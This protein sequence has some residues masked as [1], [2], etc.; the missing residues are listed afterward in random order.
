MNALTDRLKPKEGRVKRLFDGRTGQAITSLQ[1][2]HD[3]QNLVASA[4]TKRLIK[5]IY[6]FVDFNTISEVRR[7]SQ[8][9]AEPSRIITIYPNGDMVS[10]GI[11]LSISK[12]RFP[13]MKRL[14]EHIMKELPQYTGRLTTIYTTTGER[15]Q[16]IEEIAH[17]GSYVAVASPDAFQRVKYN[18]DGYKRQEMASQP[19]PAV[20]HS[21][22]SRAAQILEKSKKIL[23]PVP[24]EPQSRAPLSKDPAHAAPEPAAAASPPTIP[25]KKTGAPHPDTTGGAKKP[26][27]GAQANS[28]PNSHPTSKNNSKTN[29]KSNLGAELTEPLPQSP[30]GDIQTF[31]SNPSEPKVL[32]VKRVGEK[33]PATLT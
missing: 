8:L 30:P 27:I 25:V 33:D 12:F 11:N 15:I 1:D 21:T 4:N 23:D 24:N 26:A 2:L 5:V 22:I 7:L 17:G 10:T 32:A 18:S 31:T 13:D 9:T 19:K 20:A 28:K 3:G 29:S 6:P 14:L 16:R